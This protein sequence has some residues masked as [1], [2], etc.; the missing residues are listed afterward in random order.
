[1][2]IGERV[3]VVGG[4]GV[5]VETAL[6]LARRWES[7][8]ETI[9]LFHEWPDLTPEDEAALRR[10]GHAVTLVGRNEKLGVGL[11]G[12]TRW[13]LV[14]ELA[15][16]GVEALASTEVVAIEPDG[17]RVRG[18]NGERLLAADTVVLATGYR[19]DEALL[20]R[21]EGA[22]PEV[23]SLGDAESVQHALN[24]IGKALEV[25]LAL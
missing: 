25:A 1:V 5:G 6:Y 18:P 24:G 11:G 15:K 13:V 19:P 16:A 3:V 22:A 8:P 14:K 12:G 2:P 20:R 17:V 4:G 23:Y 21:F 7:S 10:R 9:E